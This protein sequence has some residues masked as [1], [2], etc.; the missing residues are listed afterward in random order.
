VLHLLANK[1]GVQRSFLIY[2]ERPLMSN[3]T[4]SVISNGQTG[5]GHMVFVEV[6]GS[7]SNHLKNN[8]NN[9]KINSLDPA[10]SGSRTISSFD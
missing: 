10:G 1:C 5:L 8:N 9:N 4:S 2:H 3:K 7:R 6:S